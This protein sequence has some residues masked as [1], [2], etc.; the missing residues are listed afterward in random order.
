MDAF[1]KTLKVVEQTT[2]WIIINGRMWVMAFTDV[3]Q[4][5]DALLT[6]HLEMACDFAVLN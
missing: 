5:L 3:W 1:L 6:V 2:K 4:L